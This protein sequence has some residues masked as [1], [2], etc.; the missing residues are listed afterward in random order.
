MIDASKDDF[1]AHD[2]EV[3]NNVALNFLDPQANSNKFYIAELHKANSAYAGEPYRLYVNHGRI[4]A[5]G[6]AKAEPFSSLEGAER[7]FETKLRE[8][9][10]KGYLVSD[11]ATQTAGSTKATTRIN[12]D[13]LDSGTL[14]HLTKG[15]ATK[16]NVHPK[17]LDLIEHLYA[18]TNQAISLSVTGSI[19]KDARAPLGNI[20]INGINRGRAI[21]TNI[22]GYLT[23]RPTQGQRLV[24]SLSVEYYKTIPRKLPSDLR[25]DTSWILSTK[26]RVDKEFEILDLY[27]D[28]LRML[29]VLS[30]T[31]FESRYR[32][33]FCDIRPVEDSKTLEYLSH[34]VVSTK[35]SNHNF[36][37]KLVSAYEL[38]QHNAPTF[39]QSGIQNVRH[40]F[41]GSRSANLIGILSSH[42]KLPNNLASDIHKTGAMFGGGIY[43][44][45]NATK[46]ANYA[47][48]QFGGRKNKYDTAYL[49]VAEVAMGNVYK[50]E[51]P[52]SFSEAPQG[53]HSVM[54]AKG[55]HLVNDEFIVYD[56]SQ[57]KIRY[58][59]E[60]AK[61]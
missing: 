45:H 44:A 61:V 5:K 6:S 42:L 16:A 32:A 53:Y 26:D 13:A 52:Q 21:L 31:D 9:R 40:L 59:I 23:T 46:S 28:A 41:H 43:F 58:L 39:N 10:R 12:S 36:G 17:L 37:L 48:S 11:L 14:R 47:F 33:L 54:G 22:K 18:E 29:P 4:G 24:E 15:T 8:K 38:N 60:V 51:K 19:K 49:F 50:T 3:I 30:N 7:K 55:S 1:Y 57:V 2:Y 20:G 25:T 34:K 27:E 56:P 35:A